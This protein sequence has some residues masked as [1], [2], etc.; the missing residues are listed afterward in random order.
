MK[1]IITLQNKKIIVE[2]KYDPDKVIDSIYKNGEIVPL[3]KPR[4]GAWRVEAWPKQE[5]AYIEGIGIYSV[6]FQLTFDKA[7][8]SGNNYIKK[9]A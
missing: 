4:I 5:G 7:L 3:K 1:D 8:K 6:C 2:I 9:A